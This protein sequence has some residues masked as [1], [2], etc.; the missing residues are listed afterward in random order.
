MGCRRGDGDF[1]AW[2]KIGGRDPS[3]GRP[4]GALLSDPAAL[5]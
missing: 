3:D 4:R 5:Q 1:F 2:K